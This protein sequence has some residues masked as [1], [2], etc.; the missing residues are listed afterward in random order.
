MVPNTRA[1]ERLESVENKLR[2]TEKDFEQARKHAR[3]TKDDFE[4]AMRRRSEL[5]NKA[6]SHISE[7]IGP[8]YRELTRSQNYPLGGQAYV[9]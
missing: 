7:Q 1:L 3:K 6:F 9:S 2:G 4:E 8:I 5:F